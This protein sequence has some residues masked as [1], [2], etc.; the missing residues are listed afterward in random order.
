MKRSLD[1]D[2]STHLV[3]NITT[4]DLEE[5]WNRYSCN[6]GISLKIETWN[7]ATTLRNKDLKIFTKDGSSEP[8]DPIVEMELGNN[9]R[10]YY[11]VQGAEDVSPIRRVSTGL[12]EPPENMKEIRTETNTSNKQNGVQ[13]NQ[14][15]NYY[16]TG[17][18]GQANTLRNPVDYCVRNGP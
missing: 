4:R 15:F 17:G 5:G 16:P 7:L 9:A 6:F 13:I 3:G 18:F 14:V 2:S 11:H 1:S 10:T 12:T 8:I